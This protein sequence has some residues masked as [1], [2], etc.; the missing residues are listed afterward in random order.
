MYKEKNIKTKQ[1]GKTNT[2][3]GLEKI[4]NGASILFSV[5][6]TGVGIDPAVMS[7]LFYKFTRADGANAVN[8][9]GTGLGLY[10]AREIITAHNG[11][12]WAESEGDG[13]GSQFYVELP[14]FVQ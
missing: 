13:K 2:Q 9:R 12:T 1:K 4:K 6:D 7:K 3:N 5:K 14:A 8:I 11:K 10:L